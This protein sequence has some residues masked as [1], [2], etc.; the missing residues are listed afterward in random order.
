MSTEKNLMSTEKNLKEVLR[1]LCDL[2]VEH[3]YDPYREFEW[4]AALPDRR[5]WMSADLLSVHGTRYIDDLSEDQLWALSRWE[6]VNFFSFNVHGIRELMLHVLSCIHN[7][8]YEVT[9]EYFHHF[10]DEENKHMWFFAE[11]CKRYG[12]KIY[13]TQ[14]MQF[15]TFLEDDIQTF[16]AFAKILIS[17]QISDFY[18]LRMMRDDGLPAMVQKLNRVHHEDESR[19]I[20]MGRRVV[21]AMY[22]Q[23]AEKYPAETCRRI[24]GYIRRYM[25]FFV[26]SFYNPSAYRDAGL[27]DPYEWRRRLIN[28]PARTE[29]HK[30]VFRKTLQFFRSCDLFLEE[31]QYA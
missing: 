2:S 10:L 29:F 17:E 20:A 31:R 30:R 7:T 16:V 15:P 6:L 4:P 11:F 23:I 28:D 9:S 14:K 1:R 26:Q 27:Q 13:F 24:E 22:D 21:R 5:L 8:G 12:G 25:D 3:A 18:N 19:H